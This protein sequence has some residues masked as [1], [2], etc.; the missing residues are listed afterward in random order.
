MQLIL[1]SETEQF[2]FLFSGLI[3]ISRAG[4][5]QRSR[6]YADH[7]RPGAESEG[8]WKTRMEVLPTRAA[9]A[10]TPVAAA[11]WPQSMGPDP[12][13]PFPLPQPLPPLYICM[14][15]RAVLTPAKQQRLPQGSII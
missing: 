15:C 14:G 9:A 10:S 4:G 13:A 11:P 5:G 3:L 6:R 1:H 7:C 2:Q 8:A 12:G